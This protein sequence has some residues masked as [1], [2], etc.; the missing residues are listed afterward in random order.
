M[1]LTTAS[2]HL[3]TPRALGIHHSEFSTMQTCHDLVLAALLVQARGH[4]FHSHI[5]GSSIVM[6]Q[7]ADW[8]RQNSACMHDP[9]W[10][11]CNYDVCRIHWIWC[12]ILRYSCTNLVIICCAQSRWVLRLKIGDKLLA[13]SDK[14]GC[15]GYTVTCMQKASASMSELCTI[16]CHL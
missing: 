9:H 12:R 10:Q 13:T 16:A 4:T 1:K 6:P 14:S 15:P 2:Q 5:S 11:A 8:C 3:Q 7:G